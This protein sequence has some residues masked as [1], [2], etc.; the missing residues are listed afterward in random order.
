MKFSNK[1]SIGKSIKKQHSPDYWLSAEKHK[2][3]PVRKIRK[4]S[5]LLVANQQNQNVNAANVTPAKL[6]TQTVKPIVKPNVQPYTGVDKNFQFN[7]DMMN[8][9]RAAVKNTNR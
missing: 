7:N 6:P 5:N 1:Y 8:M 4:A 2:R 9:Y 3:F